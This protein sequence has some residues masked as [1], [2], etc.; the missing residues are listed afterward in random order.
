[1]IKIHRY[2]YPFP[3]SNFHIFEIATYYLT[4]AFDLAKVTSMSVEL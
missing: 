4:L 2:G 3:V 1:M